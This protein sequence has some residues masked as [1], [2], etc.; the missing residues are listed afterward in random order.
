METKPEPTKST[1]DHG[2]QAVPKMTPKQAA[3]MVSKT[4]EVINNSA[5]KVNDMINNKMGPIGP[6]LLMSLLIMGVMATLEN[7]K[8]L[9]VPAFI[10][11]LRFVP[12]LIEVSEKKQDDQKK[13]LPKDKQQ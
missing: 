8:L 13:E 1:E 11:G 7:A 4:N 6:L 2:T 5:Q 9:M 3:E 12:R 10:I